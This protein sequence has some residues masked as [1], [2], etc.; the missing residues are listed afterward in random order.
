MKK[1]FALLLALILLTVPLFA[2]A[3]I[4]DLP[5]ERQKPLLVDEGDI[6]TDDEEAT[7]LTELERVSSEQKCDIAVIIPRSLGYKSSDAFTEDYYDENGY[8]QNTTKDGIMLMVC[9]E[10]RD[11]YLDAAGA[12][13]DWFSYSTRLQMEDHFLNDLSNGNYLSAFL[14]FVSDCEEVL[15]ITD[16]RETLYLSDLGGFL[17][18]EQQRVL[19]RELESHSHVGSLCDIVVLTV[20]DLAGQT[21]KEYVESVYSSGAYLH[22][23]DHDKIVMVVDRAASKCYCVTGGNASEYFSDADLSAMEADVASRLTGG[24]ALEAFKGFCN[25]AYGQIRA[26]YENQFNTGPTPAPRQTRILSGFRALVSAFIGMIAGLG[27]GKS[28]KSQLRS[29]GQ[30]ESAS[31]YLVR[32]RMQLTDQ[33][34]LYLYANVSKSAR[35]SESRGSSSGGGHSGGSHFSSG[36]ASHSGHGGKF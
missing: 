35:V 19:T 29:V 27:T 2:S 15:K 14:T 13:Q 24:A 3:D 21:A 1:R 36:G 23:V 11:Y 32:D 20:N 8:G 16:R 6:L 5:T 10:E 4:G 31:D 7:L 17:N 34:D 33:Q 25:T 22:G 12:A 28:L 30:Q 18:A 9:M 26:Y